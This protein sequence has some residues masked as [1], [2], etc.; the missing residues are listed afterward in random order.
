MCSGS[1]RRSKIRRRRSRSWSRIHRREGKG[2][3]HRGGSIPRI[4][5]S[6][7]SLSNNRV[8]TDIGQSGT[9]PDMVTVM[10]HEAGHRILRDRRLGDSIVEICF[11]FLRRE[12]FNMYRLNRVL[13]KR[14]LIL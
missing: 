1:R 8:G 14:R 7:D 12:R 13:G 2:I 5:D 3:N 4:E 9:I 10:A 6:T 11:L